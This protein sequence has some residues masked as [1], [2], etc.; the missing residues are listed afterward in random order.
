MRKIAILLISIVI[1]SSLVSG[2]SFT[3]IISGNILNLVAG[4]AVKNK[5][6]KTTLNAPSDS[7]V[8]SG[9]IV[10]FDW[11]YNDADGDEQQEY[12]LQ[13]DDDYGFF[14][15]FT[16]YGL[17]ETVN[18]ISIPTGDG[19]YY[20]RVQSKDAYG[21]GKWSDS[22]RFYLDESEKVCKDGTIFWKCS[23]EKPFYCDAGRLIEKC[24]KCGC[25]AN[26][27]CL[28]SGFCAKQTCGDGTIYGG[29]SENQP[30]YCRNGILVNACN[31]CGCD[32][33]LECKGDGSC[34]KSI[35]IFEEKIEEKSS[36]L[37]RIANFFKSLLGF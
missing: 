6:P 7:E 34:V 9:K 33:G 2:F 23:S 13:I 21:W 22:R 3:D 16:Y 24:T 27:V 29:C 17:K 26:E 10:K 25:N 37:E 8:V 36:L 28:E 4:K 5:A 15:P 35:I 11:A 18:K 30:K 12:I 14:S 31:F 19:Q 32:G 20:W 1:F